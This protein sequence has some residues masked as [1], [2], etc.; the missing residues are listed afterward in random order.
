[1]GWACPDKYSIKWGGGGS[2][3]GFP[4][5]LCFFSIRPWGCAPHPSRGCA[6]LHPAR[7]L[8]PLDPDAARLGAFPN[9]FEKWVDIC[10]VQCYNRQAFKRERNINGTQVWRN[11]QTRMV[12]VH[13]SASSCRFK[14]CYLHQVKVRTQLPRQ[15]KGFGLFL[16]EPVFTGGGC[17]MGEV[18]SPGSGEF[19]RSTWRLS[20]K[21][22]RTM[23]GKDPPRWRATPV[24]TGS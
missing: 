10:G 11:W 5:K 18:F 1:M 19:S 6:P 9:F 20:R 12:Q 24:N 8:W 13:M 17:R 16:L 7:G 21:I 2:L 4:C 22:P 14:S 3:F 23:T 15:G